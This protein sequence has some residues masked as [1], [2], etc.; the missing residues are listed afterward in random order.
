MILGFCL[1]DRFGSSVGVSDDVIIVGATGD[2]SGINGSA[3]LFERN[4]GGMDNWGEIKKLVDP[5]GASDD[6]FGISV[7]IS[8]DLAIVG[9]YFDDFPSGF[10]EGSATIFTQDLGGFKNWGRVKKIFGSE[11]AMLDVNRFGSD[12]VLE[13]D[14]ALVGAESATVN[15]QAEQGAVYVFERDFGGASNWGET[16]IITASDG[17]NIDYFGRRLDISKKKLIVGSYDADINGNYA[18]GAAYLY[19]NLTTS[20]PTLTEWS[21]IILGISICIVGI[22]GIRQALIHPT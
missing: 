3:Y 14:L 8:G 20:I 18:Q 19:K 11:N 16:Q 6:F 5:D 1:N 2:F 13:D 21:I 7:D 4:S 15:G 22:I 10:N 9:A 12:V 17:D